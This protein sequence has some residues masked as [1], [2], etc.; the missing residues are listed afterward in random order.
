MKP[1][2]LLTVVN[3]QNLPTVHLDEAAQRKLGVADAQ[4]C[5]PFKGDS[6][7]TK[8]DRL[9]DAATPTRYSG[10][11]AEHTLWWLWSTRPPMTYAL[12]GSSSV[13]TLGESEVR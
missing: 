3:S 13:S 12:C 9:A 4:L 10:S 8:P 5:G 11:G 7:Q 1:L 6:L 2:P